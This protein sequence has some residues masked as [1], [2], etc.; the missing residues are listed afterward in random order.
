MYIGSWACGRPEGRGTYTSNLGSSFV[1]LWR[2]GWADGSGTYNWLD[3]R[4]DVGRFQGEA[5]RLPL[6]AAI[7]EGVRW[8]HDRT[9]AALLKN[10]IETGE[11]LSLSA[12]EDI[13][14]RLGIVPAV[15]V[16]RSPVTHAPARVSKREL[17]TFQPFLSKRQRT[18]IDSRL[19]T[20]REGDEADEGSDTAALP[21]EQLWEL[22]CPK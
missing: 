15:P 20:A 7:G 13:G 4:A 16:V 12:A 19:T 17:E 8:N 6:L 18:A 3:G 11:Q 1:G 10:G 22:I 2:R 14:Q 5:D 21:F 9:E